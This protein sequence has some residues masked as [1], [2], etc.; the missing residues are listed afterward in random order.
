MKGV[1]SRRSGYVLPVILILAGCAVSEPDLVPKDVMTLP[2]IN[3]EPYGKIAVYVDMTAVPEDQRSPAPVWETE[4]GLRT[5]GFD[6]VGHNVFVEFLKARSVPPAAIAEAGTLR[7]A[8]EKLGPSALVL[9]RVAGF[10]AV[11][12]T[13]SRDKIVTP[14]VPGVREAP[15][16]F[17]EQGL[18]DRRKWAI[19][20]SLTFEMM[21]TATATK[22]WACSLA[23]SGFPFEGNL[24]A[25]F[26][27][28]V[29]RCLE[30]LPGR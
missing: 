18:H 1:R 16:T 29:G 30:T 4:A 5:R 15:M 28:V 8:R 22:V 20:L 2:D 17:L 26:K 9:V 14:G 10:A 19:D 3:Y 12:K 21:D 23:C 24:Q 7:A 11:A 27:R 13:E 6:V 25:F